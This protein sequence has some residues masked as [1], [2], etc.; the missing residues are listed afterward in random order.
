MSAA[1]PRHPNCDLPGDP[2]LIL[3]TNVDLGDDKDDV[4]K[5]LSALV[6]K[7]T[8]KPESYVAVSVTDKASMC[9]GGSTDPLALGVMYSLGAINMANNGKVQS[10]VTDILGKYGVA[11]NRIY[12]N[13]F[14]MPRDCVG[15]NRA[16]FA[17]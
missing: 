6:A 17:G 15:Y 11:D 12:V 2:S 14:D 5:Q 1:D 4:L 8:G 7:S 3:T 9:F 13:F 16:T 10:G